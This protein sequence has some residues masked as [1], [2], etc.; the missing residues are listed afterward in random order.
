MSDKITLED[1][2]AVFNSVTPSRRRWVR[3]RNTMRN[4]WKELYQVLEKASGRDGGKVVVFDKN[5]HEV[6]KKGTT[7]GAVNKTPKTEKAEE[8]K[9]AEAAPAPKT[10]KK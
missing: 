4:E 2:L 1:V 6:A 3:N 9:K 5:W 10:A 8:P 7:T